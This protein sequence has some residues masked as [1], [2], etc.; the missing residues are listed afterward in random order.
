M[1]AALRVGDV[2]TAFA[3]MI[4]GAMFD[5]NIAKTCC[6]PKE[7]ACATGTRPSSL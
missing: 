7:T 3:R 4:I 1:R 6:N 5:T 2:P